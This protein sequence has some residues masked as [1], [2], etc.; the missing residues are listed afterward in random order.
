MLSLLLRSWKFPQGLLNLGIECILES[1]QMREL[2][3]IEFEKQLL[4]DLARPHW[5]VD[6]NEREESLT[7]IAF[8]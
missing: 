8:Q 1:H 5:F 7:K 2:V 3:G 6:R 4:N